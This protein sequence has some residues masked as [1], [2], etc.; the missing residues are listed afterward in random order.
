[1]EGGGGGGAIGGDPFIYLFNVP[2]A[3]VGSFPPHIIVLTC[4]HGAMGRRIDLSWW[5]H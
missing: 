4:A 2:L 3:D 1:M 5:T